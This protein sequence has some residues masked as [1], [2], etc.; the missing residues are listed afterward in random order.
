MENTL[1][2]DPKKL[3]LTSTI[4]LS[5]LSKI[6]AVSEI[7]GRTSQ[8]IE[9]LSDEEREILQGLPKDSA[10]LIVLSGPSK[11]SRFLLNTASIS[12]GRNAENDIFLDDVT[13]S[14]KHATITRSG[15][16]EFSLK[17]SG[18]LNG[19]YIDS[20]IRASA[21]LVHGNEIHIGKYKLMFFH[22]G[23]K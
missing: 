20:I 12:I 8:I 15:D 21:L 17:D 3:D 18:S 7:S 23:N 4:H 19:T 1:P 16:G 2:Q 10:M 11:G 14:R 13:V 5:H 22:G 6:S 9:S